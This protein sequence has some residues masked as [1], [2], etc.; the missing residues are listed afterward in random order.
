[1]DMVTSIMADGGMTDVKC[2]KLDAKDGRT[3]GTAVF[4]VSCTTA[5]K[6]KLYD[7]QVWTNGSEV[8]KWYFKKKSSTDVSRQ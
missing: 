8:H 6:D 1:M 4:Y 7:E 2:F 3:F 5:Q